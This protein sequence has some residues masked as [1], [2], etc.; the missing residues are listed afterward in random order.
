MEGLDLT[1]RDELEGGCIDREVAVAAVT[2]AETYLGAYLDGGADLGHSTTTDAVRP[3]AEDVLAGRKVDDNLFGRTKVCDRLG[4]HEYA[5][6]ASGST[7]ATITLY[8][9]PTAFD[10]GL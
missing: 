9:D 5:R 7:E 8:G 3:C 2:D 6:G 1:D 4:V 10:R